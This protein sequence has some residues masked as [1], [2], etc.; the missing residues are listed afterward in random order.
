VKKRLLE[1]EAYTDDAALMQHL[2]VDELWHSADF[3]D[4]HDTEGRAYGNNILRNGNDIENRDDLDVSDGAKEYPQT[5][6]INRQ[7]FVDTQSCICTHGGCYH[8]NSLIFILES[9]P[10]IVLLI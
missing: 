3:G 5:I 7:R 6:G 2:C 10:L 8:I 1:H 9:V 4:V